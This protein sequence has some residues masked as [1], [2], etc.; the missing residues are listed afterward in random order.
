MLLRRPVASCLV[1]VAA[2]LAVYLPDV[3][4]G[5]VKDDF[6]WIAGSRL[7]ADVL[8][9]APTGFFR[10]AVSASFAINRAVCGVD[11][12]CYGLTNLA[13]L[14]A[15]ALGVAHLARAVGLSA[16][17]AIA[18]SAI[19][20][21]NWHGINMA[22]LWISGRTALLL[23]V[24][25]TWGVASLLRGRWIVGLPLVL[26]AMLSK[27]EAVVLPAIVAWGLG[28]GRLGAVPTRERA[29]AILGSVVMLAVYL[30]LR[31][32]SGAFTPDTAPSYYQL[33]F[34]AGRLLSNL[35]QYADRAGTMAAAA[36]LLF[37]IVA[38]PGRIAFTASDRRAV[39][40][41]VAWCVLGFALTIFLPVRSSLYVCFPSVGVALVAAV[42]LD[43]W[44]IVT[45]AGGQS[46][47][48][49][50]GLLLPF[51]LWPVYHA[52][53]RGSVGEAELSRA[54]LA[55]LQRVAAERGE[56]AIVTLRD[57]P[58]ARPSLDDAFGTIAQGAAD[59]MITPKIVVWVDPPPRDAALAGLEPPARSD[60]TIALRDGVLVRLP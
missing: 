59:L 41:G 54:A 33:D 29:V 40:F 21:F 44:W 56:G 42:V 4:H 8:L 19:W 25:A 39:A 45:P 1:L 47:A 36:L 48:V 13:L 7:S 35:L 46:R 18:A 15:S 11:S 26:L 57:D 37:W 32:E 51:A 3:G 27:E 53:N 52:R 24:F 34:T 9:G 12:L 55:A 2:A 6:L 23:T 38:R 20:I 49:I 16:G 60:V 22:T 31:L 14:F 30:A 5:F 10:P 43:R 50:A 17:A 28:R 58:G